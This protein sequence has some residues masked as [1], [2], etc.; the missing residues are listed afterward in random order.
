MS[1]DSNERLIKIGVKNGDVIID[2]GDSVRWLAF[3]PIQ[4]HALIDG[5]SGV[6]H[7]LE[8]QFGGVQ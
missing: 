1:E 3:T 4:A 7:L 6:L 2:F 5:I 8:N